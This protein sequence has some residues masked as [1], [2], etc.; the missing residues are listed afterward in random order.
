MP[1]R[2]ERPTVR[3]NRIVGEMACHDL[4]QPVSLRWD[5]PMHSTPGSVADLVEIGGGV[6][7]G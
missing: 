3:G 5:R 2:G 7:S 6:V 4:P 1:E